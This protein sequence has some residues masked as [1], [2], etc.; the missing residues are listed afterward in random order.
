MVYKNKKNTAKSVVN[1]KKSLT[2]HTNKVLEYD[3][4]IKSQEFSLFS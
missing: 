1:V 4:T 3:N 2:L